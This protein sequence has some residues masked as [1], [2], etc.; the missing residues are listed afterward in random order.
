MVTLAAHRSSTAPRERL[1]S[2][3]LLPEQDVWV[4]VS[5]NGDLR[6]QDHGE[7]DGDHGLRQIGKGSEVELLAANTRDFLYL[8]CRRWT[9]SRRL[10]IHEIPQNGEAKHLAEL[11]DFH[12]AR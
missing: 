6:R 1:T 11:T 9:L 7:T 8:F 12:A 3:D 2:T 4:S 10:A 5:A